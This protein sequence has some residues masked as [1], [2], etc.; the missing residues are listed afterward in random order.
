M[1]APMQK[2]RLG[3]GLAS[4]IG[5]TSA[6]VETP[7]PLE[8]EQRMIPIDLLHGSVLNPRKDFPEAELLE[9]ADSIRVKGLVQPLVARK[10]P[11]VAGAYEIVAGER[12]WRASQKAGLHQVPVIV[13]ELDDQDV[14]ELAIIENVQRSDLNAIEEAG[15]YNELMQRFSYSQEQLSEIIGK[16]RSHVANTLR[17]L[18]LPESVQNMV[19]S[20]ELSAGH[21]RTL[22]GHKN[23]EALAKEILAGSLN[24]RDT[25]AL[26]QSGMGGKGKSGSSSGRAREKDADTLAFEKELTDILGLKVE[27]KR[28]SGE[29]GQLII[30][31]SNFDQL[32]YIR[33]RLFGTG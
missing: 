29:S 15:G 8:G 20:G 6:D 12:R 3:R 2:S 25:E 22:V 17:L 23:A 33:A 7:L 5:E 13:R 19:Q 27:I 30:K 14:L 10:H 11:K 9:L 26:V 1:N 28:G 4:L 16:S 24:V 21:A 32:E 31:Y 18:R